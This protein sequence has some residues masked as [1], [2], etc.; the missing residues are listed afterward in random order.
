[1]GW[2][3]T[4]TI[5]SSDTSRGEEIVT[6]FQ[7]PK[8]LKVLETVDKNKNQKSEIKLRSRRVNKNDA[9]EKDMKICIGVESFFKASIPC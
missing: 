5:E 7:M 9:D 8:V 4:V 3:S 1:M 6:E 2:V